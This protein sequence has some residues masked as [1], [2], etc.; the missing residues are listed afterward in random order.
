MARQV[1]WPATWL[2]A[3]THFYPLPNCH[4]PFFSCYFFPCWGPQ[5]GFV[6]PHNPLLLHPITSPK[7]LQAMLPQS[8]G[9]FREVN[10]CHVWPLGL[11]LSCDIP[12]RSWV[13]GL[14]FL[15]LGY[16]IFPICS[17]A[18]ALLCACGNKTWI[19]SITRMEQVIVVEKSL[20]QGTEAPS[21]DK[22]AGP[23]CCRET[24]EPLDCCLSVAHPCALPLQLILLGAEGWTR[25]L[26]RS[27]AWFCNAV[28]IWVTI[29]ACECTHT[30]PHLQGNLI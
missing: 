29:T 23:G 11:I 26:P 13:R 2:H 3:T 4:D 1:Y 10:W 5:L 25:D 30:L 27:S 28:I 21:V 6:R 14:C 12:G 17:G 20:L 8:V 24:A 18:S 9:C 16:H 7:F 15:W 19:T 22:G